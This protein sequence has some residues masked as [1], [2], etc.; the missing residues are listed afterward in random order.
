[1]PGS[2]WIV[3][4]FIAHLAT[5]DEPVTQM[6]QSYQRPVDDPVEGRRSA[7]RDAWDVDRWNDRRVRERR[8][9]GVDELLVEAAA[10]R[11]ACRKAL[12]DFTGEQLERTLHFGGDSKRPASEIRLLDYLRGWCKH[13]PMHAVDMV[14]ALPEH[15]TPQMRAWFDDPVIAGYQAAMN[16]PQ[17]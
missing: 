6:F 13:D 3:H 17:A 10:S 16:R 4:D 9:L 12:S 1:V 5:I 8:T 11:D 7:A 14:R 15:D 2:E